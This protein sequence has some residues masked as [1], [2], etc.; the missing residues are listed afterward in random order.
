[1]SPAG[2]LLI[3]ADLLREVLYGKKS[4]Q[5][6]ANEPVLQGGLLHHQ[7]NYVFQ[8]RYYWTIWC[9]FGSWE[10]IGS[11]TMSKALA[12]SWRNI[13][14]SFGYF[15]LINQVTIS[16]TIWPILSAGMWRLPGTFSLNDNNQQPASLL[17]QWQVIFAY[18]EMCSKVCY[19]WLRRAIILHTTAPWTPKSKRLNRGYWR[20]LQST[21]GYGKWFHSF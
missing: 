10:I 6:C 20:T 16:G 4:P 19:R 15:L 12:E 14:K 11:W 8:T 17:S 2:G 18:Q 21:W 7:G 3:T 9:P 1:M 5:E 13:I